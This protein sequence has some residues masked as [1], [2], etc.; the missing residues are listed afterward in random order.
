MVWETAVSISLWA[1]Q[2]DMQA[3]EASGYLQEQFTKLGPY[4]ASSPTTEHF[5]VRV[6]A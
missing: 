3:S 2:A 6:R 1:T 4:L 5:A